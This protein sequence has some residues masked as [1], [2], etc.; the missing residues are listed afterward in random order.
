MAEEPIAK[1]LFYILSCPVCK[2]KIKYSEGKKTV[3]CIDC[4]IK[5]PIEDGIPI[6]MPPKG[7]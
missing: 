4:R 2:G 3:E 7:K 1:E 6:L 5:Y